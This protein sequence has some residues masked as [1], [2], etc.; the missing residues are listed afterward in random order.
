MSIL[1]E[2]TQLEYNTKA[3]ADS[4]AEDLGTSFLFDFD[5]GDF[6]TVDGKIVTITDIEAIKGWVEKCLRTERFQYAIYA[7]EDKNEYGVTIEG[8]IGS[9]LPRAFV[10]AELKR[11]ITGALTRHPRISSISGLSIDRDGAKVNV[12]FTL[13]LNDGKTVG[14]EVT[15]SG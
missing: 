6:V 5:A 14:Q 2:I 3:A 9:V 7:R 4:S 15:V 8:L 13:N 11:E 1:P 10:E 12:A